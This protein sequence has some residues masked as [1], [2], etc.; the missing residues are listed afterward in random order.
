VAKAIEDGAEVLDAYSVPLKGKPSG[1]LPAFYEQ[2]G[3]GE[4]GRIPFDP[5]Y[6]EASN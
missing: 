5:K 1:L 6:I 3:F 4:L 2:F